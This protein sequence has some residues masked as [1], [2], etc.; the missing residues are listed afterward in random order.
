[1][2]FRPSNIDLTINLCHSTTI[3]ND[4]FGVFESCILQEQ[5]LDQA[6]PR[7]VGTRELSKFSALPRKVGRSPEGH[8]KEAFV[9]HT[10]E[11]FL[12]RV[13][14]TEAAAI[15]ECLAGSLHHRDLEATKA[16]LSP[17]PD[18]KGLSPV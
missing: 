7:I 3:R 15:P 14:E 17:D 5:S 1:M 12:L 18:Q 9:Q 11:A 16:H 10:G 6:C 4:L 13:K 2:A 8:L